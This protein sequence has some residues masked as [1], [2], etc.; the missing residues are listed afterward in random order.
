M[1]KNK[2]IFITST[3]TELGK[4]YCTVKIL[5]ELKKRNLNFKV[6][7]PIL[8]G[9]NKNKIELCDSYKILATHNKLVNLE[10][11]KLITPWL[12][13]SPIAPSLAASKEN[14]K[15]IYKEVLEWCKKKKKS[16]NKETLCLFEGAGGVFVPIEKNKTI[17]DLIKDTN[18]FVILV[19]G[20]YLGS[21]SHTISV[22]K[23]LEFYGTK[24]INVV[25]NDNQNSEIS[26]KDTKCLLE[27]TTDNKIKFRIVLKNNAQKEKF[28][29]IV[30][31][32]LNCSN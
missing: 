27:K 5:K 29:N 18:S 1:K 30:D 4:T 19:V 13:K 23:N 9:F 11:I 31:D 28:N 15:L 6:Y 2:S 3:G 20:N 17:F 12:Y 14:K 22:I 8:S 21:I 7:K 10:K 16:M 25:I 24:L 26:V 32:I